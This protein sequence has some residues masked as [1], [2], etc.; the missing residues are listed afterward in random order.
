[1]GDGPPAQ[2]AARRRSASRRATAAVSGPRRAEGELAAVADLERQHGGAP[3]RRGSGAGS[4]TGS[5]VS[6]SRNARTLA[7][8]AAAGSDSAAPLPLIQLDHAITT[9][10]AGKAE[11][12]AKPT[13][14]PS[15][16]A[17]SALPP[18]SANH[19][20]C[21]EVSYDDGATWHRMSLT[22]TSAPVGTP[23]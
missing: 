10:T 20:G 6:R 11:R 9:D 17:L 1:M 16:L 7:A 13:L 4:G 18:T 8:S 14:T 12:N 2:L 23:R 3:D 5:G 22:R 21:L 15:H 19:N